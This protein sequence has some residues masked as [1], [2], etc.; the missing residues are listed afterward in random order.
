VI[1]ATNHF[2]GERPPFPSLA[3][4]VRSITNGPVAKTFNLNFASIYAA[5]ANEPTPPAC[6]YCGD[7]EAREVT[8]ELIRAAGFEPVFAGGLDNARALEDALPFLFA[9]SQSGTGPFFYRFGQP[10]EL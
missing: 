9:I 3:H 8:E 1:D 7:D 2:R 10:G 5:L 4:Q 6:P